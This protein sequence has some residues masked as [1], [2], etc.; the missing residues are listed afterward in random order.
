MVFD[1]NIDLDGVFADMHGEYERLTG[2]DVRGDIMLPPD[3]F[4]APV[5]A[6]YTKGNMW[7]RN[8]KPL[9]DA[10]VLWGHVAA[11]R[12][13]ILTAVGEDHI[14]SIRQE[15]R[16]WVAEHLGAH[17]PVVFSN[18]SKEKGNFVKGPGSVLVDDYVKSCESWA[19]AGGIA[20]LHTSAEDTIRQLRKLYILR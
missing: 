15:K 7:F 6:E 5:M 9:P 16:E 4:W 1:L 11:K 8:L 13:T 2:I 14:P 3:E 20:I 12:P 10:M 18:T 19:A 17:V